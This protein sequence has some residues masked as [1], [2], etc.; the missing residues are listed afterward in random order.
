MCGLTYLF[1]H[2]SHIRRRIQTWRGKQIF[3]KNID[4]LSCLLAV[5]CQPDAICRAYK[6]SAMV[7]ERQLLCSR[8]QAL[9]NTR[10][11]Q[12]KRH[13]LGIIRQTIFAMHISKELTSFW[14]K[15]N[16]DRLY[17]LEFNPIRARIHDVWSMYRIF[18]AI[19]MYSTTQYIVTVI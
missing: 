10:R 3:W 6:A 16:F 14:F 11:S 13:E 9:F 19:Q 7:N 2:P 4:V 18:C 8:L 17:A 1:H 15:S 5:I 12:Y